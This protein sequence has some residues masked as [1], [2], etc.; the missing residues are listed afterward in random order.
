MVALV[1][2]HDAYERG[3]YRSNAVYIHRAIGYNLERKG[4]AKQRGGDWF[5]MEFAITE[6]GLAFFDANDI[7]I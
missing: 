5:H 1:E 4:F 2:R 7:H 6:A 3:E